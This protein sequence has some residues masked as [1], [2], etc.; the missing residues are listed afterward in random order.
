MPQ[1][2]YKVQDVYA[3]DPVTRLRA[4]EQ[5]ENVPDVTASTA[6]NTM[7]LAMPGADRF[8]SALQNVKTLLK[9]KELGLSGSPGQYASA[10]APSVPSFKIHQYLKGILGL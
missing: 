3:R 9:L 4:L 2:N 10:V 7:A 1:N 8:M 5:T 6:A